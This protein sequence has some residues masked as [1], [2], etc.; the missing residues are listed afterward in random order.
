MSVEVL[1]AQQVSE[2]RNPNSAGYKELM[3]NVKAIA[4]KN[5]SNLPGLGK[6]L[7]SDNSIGVTKDIRD[8]LIGTLVDSTY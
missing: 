7:T 5:L 6:I 1:Y 4:Y 3:G 8:T 2:F